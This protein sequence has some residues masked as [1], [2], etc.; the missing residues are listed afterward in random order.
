MSSLEEPSPNSHPN[1]H[2]ESPNSKLFEETI[3][4]TNH[5][6]ENIELFKKITVPSTTKNKKQESIS[7]LA[8]IT[9]TRSYNIN[10]NTDHEG[11]DDNVQKTICNHRIENVATSTVVN[12]IFTTKCTLDIRP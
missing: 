3:T 2:D 4:I 5:A 1:H 8:M 11:K 9:N 12:N 10:N 6:N 7:N